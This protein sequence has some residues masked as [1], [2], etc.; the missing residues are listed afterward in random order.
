M[1]ECED[2][3]ERDVSKQT[4]ELN[5]S[6]RRRAYGQ[7][8]NQSFGSMGSSLSVGCKDIDRSMSN[9]MDESMQRFN[10]EAGNSGNP[11]DE[12]RAINKSKNA[13]ASP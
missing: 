10:I 2:T 5:I 12:V 11:D 1:D 6:K 3:P 13:A 4:I 8:K 9:S 7:S